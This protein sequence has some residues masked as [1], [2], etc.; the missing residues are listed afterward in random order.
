LYAHYQATR[1]EHDRL[2]NRFEE[3]KASLAEVG[4]SI[5]VNEKFYKELH[6]KIK[7]WQYVHREQER[8]RAEMI[9]A[10]RQKIN[11]EREIQQK[12]FEKTSLIKSITK[13]AS[14]RASQELKHYFKTNEHQQQFM[15]AALHALKRN[16]HE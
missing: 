16:A 1:D 3:T 8:I 10:Q 2:L 9:K 7:H 5:E 4:K 12:E 14:E 13:E 11:Y 6:E 15:H